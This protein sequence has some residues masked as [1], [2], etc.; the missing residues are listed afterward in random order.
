M[1]NSVRIDE[2]LT[3]TGQVIAE[4]M[5]Q[6]VQEG[7]RSVL[8]LRSPDELGFGKGEQEMIEGLGLHYV[9]VPFKVESLSEELITA[10]LKELERLPKPAVIH[11]GAGFRSATIA[12]L[13]VAIREGLTPEQ[14]LARARAVGF[15]HLDHA[16]INPQI[17]QFFLQ[18]IIKHANVMP[19]AA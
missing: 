3:V 19:V 18:Y 9:N 10:I 8:N 1:I 6:A 2:D 15:P 4:Q 13:S 17:K 14:T 5:M 7:F 16:Y 12:L 11:C